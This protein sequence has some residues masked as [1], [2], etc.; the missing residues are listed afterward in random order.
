MG[1]TPLTNPVIVMKITP[2]DSENQR[3]LL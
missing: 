1:K 2:K 3:T